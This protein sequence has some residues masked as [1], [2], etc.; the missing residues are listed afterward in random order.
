MNAMAMYYAPKV[1]YKNNL[2]FN[3]MNFNGNTQN[4]REKV[5]KFNE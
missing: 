2:I 5:K 1:W 3:F 4:L